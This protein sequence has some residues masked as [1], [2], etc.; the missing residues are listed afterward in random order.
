MESPIITLTTDWSLSNHFVGK[1]KGRLYSLLPEVRIVDISHEVPVADKFSAA[2]LVRNTYEDFPVGTI[3]LIDVSGT[4]ATGDIVVVEHKGH[5][6]ITVDNGLPALL[7]DGQEVKAF[8]VSNQRVP[9]TGVFVAYE[10]FCA[11]AADLVGGRSVQSMGDPVEEFRSAQFYRPPATPEQIITHV[12]FIDTFGNAYLDL[13]YEDFEHHRQGRPFEMSVREIKINKIETPTPYEQHP[14]FDGTSQLSLRLLLTVA[15]TGNLV[16]STSLPY[17]N[18][19]RLVGIRK[20]QQI[21]ISFK[22]PSDK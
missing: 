19:S 14:D 15:V 2:F 8:R 17:E 22:T 16:I 13:S 20:M 10:V 11:L 21:R 5:F 7:F 12:I 1:V 6:F 3:H 9:N 18:A 4:R